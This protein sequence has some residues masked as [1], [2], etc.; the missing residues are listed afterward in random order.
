MPKVTGEGIQESRML[1]LWNVGI[2]VKAKI[3]A[4]YTLLEEPERWNFGIMF[5]E[6]R[7]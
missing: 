1:E 6:R 2:M 3:D 4:G 5:K 7:Q